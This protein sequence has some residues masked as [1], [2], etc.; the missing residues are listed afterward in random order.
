MHA[1]T[2]P[3]I[4][5]CMHVAFV[6]VYVY[7][8]VSV[9]V[10]DVYAIVVAIAVVIV[11]LVA[12]VMHAQTISSSPSQSSCMPPSLDPSDT[13][14]NPSHPSDNQCRSAHGSRVAAQDEI[15]QVGEEL[16]CQEHSVCSRGSPW[17]CSRGGPWPL[18]QVRVAFGDHV[19]LGQVVSARTKLH[20]LHPRAL[21]VDLRR[22]GARGRRERHQVVLHLVLTA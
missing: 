9:S 12:V 18:C 13:S 1:R 5:T 6:D 15:D 2:R 17:P 14:D 22:E 19:R 21:E 11:F 8:I 3:N 20:L 16:A 4:H 7:V 10:V